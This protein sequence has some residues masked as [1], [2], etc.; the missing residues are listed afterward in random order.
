MS[1]FGR[2]GKR[3]AQRAPEP[4]PPRELPGIIEGLT[5]NFRELNGKRDGLAGEV[6]KLRRRLAE[7]EDELDQLRLSWWPWQP[8][9][10]QRL[11]LY[12]DMLRAHLD[13][14]SSELE[15]TEASIG[16]IRAALVGQYAV[17]QASSRPVEALTMPC[18]ACDSRLFRSARLPPAGAGAKAGMSVSPRNV[19]LPGRR[20]GQVEHTP[21][22]GWRVCDLAAENLSG[23]DAIRIGRADSQRFQRGQASSRVRLPQPFGPSWNVVTLA[24]VNPPLSGGI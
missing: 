23:K 1:R 5:G 13:G 6:G 18:P 16:A 12:R 4:G 21:P 10:K 22:S 20:D 3:I 15:A 24:R 8:D 2:D 11:E 7:A 9:E 17:T 19:V 14:V